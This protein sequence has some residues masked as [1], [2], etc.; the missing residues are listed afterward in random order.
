L[1]KRVLAAEPTRARVLTAV[2]QI[3]IWQFDMSVEP[4]KL[5]DLLAMIQE[6]QDNIPTTEGASVKS[7]E[8]IE[9]NTATSRKGTL[10]GPLSNSQD[11]E[12]APCRLSC[13]HVVRT[14]SPIKLRL[15]LGRPLSKPP[16]SGGL[17]PR[18]TGVFVRLGSRNSRSPT[19]SAND[20]NVKTRDS[21]ETPESDGA[22]SD[23]A[24]ESSSKEES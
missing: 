13:N 11:P 8:A 23:Y 18:A 17:Q 10:F 20:G 3:I 24:A 21:E 7:Q 5:D 15:A 2:R 4:S 1:R 6:A 14:L 16:R 22:D 9:V 12:S 19:L